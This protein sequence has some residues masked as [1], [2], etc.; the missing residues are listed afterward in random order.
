MSILINKSTRV[1]VQGITGRDGLFHALKMK[2]YG[3]DVVGGTSPGKGGTLVEH[4]PVF[5][6]MYDAV[7]QTQ[8]NNFHYI[9]SG[10]F[11]S[12]CHYGSG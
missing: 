6:T 9:C 2:E 4:I 5:N 11:C 8:A 3:T 1:I 7:Q 12:R 10:P